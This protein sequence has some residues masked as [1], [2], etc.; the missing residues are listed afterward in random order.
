MKIKVKKEM[1]LH[2]LIQWARENNVKGETFT[3]NYGRNV[4]FYSD[5]SF[6]T[7]EPIYHWDTFTV[8]A[9]EEITERTVIPLLLE[10]YEFEGELVFLPQKRSTI[11]SLLKQSDREENIT[12]KILYLIN[13][14]GTLTLIWKDGE[15]V[16]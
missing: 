12:T 4:K 16:G 9:E 8:K 2:Q 7:M 1:N 5:G 13:D 11:E 6:N 10:V 15:L 14:D 3:S